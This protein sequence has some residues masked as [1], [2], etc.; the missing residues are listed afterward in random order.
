[1]L[2]III[3]NFFQAQ[4][5]R[6]GSHF[7]A[8]SQNINRDQ[9]QQ[10][11]FA[12]ENNQEVSSARE[13]IE[14]VKG[15][16][17]SQL[18]LSHVM[19]VLPHYPPIFNSSFGLSESKDKDTIYV[20]YD[21]GSQNSDH[22]DPLSGSS[23]GYS[24]HPGLGAYQTQTKIL[25]FPMKNISDEKYIFH[26]GIREVLAPDLSQHENRGPYKFTEDDA[27]E[28]SDSKPKSDTENPK[29]STAV[30]TEHS[31]NY[32]NYGAK[33]SEKFE[34]ISENS[35]S[36][37]N[38]TSEVVRK[39]FASYPWNYRVSKGRFVAPKTSEDEG[40]ESTESLASTSNSQVQSQLDIRKT[41]P[42]RNRSRYNVDGN[43]KKDVRNNSRSRERVIFNNKKSESHSLENQKL[44]SQYS[45]GKKL[46]N[47]NFEEK[48][49]SNQKS[50]IQTNLSKTIFEDNFQESKNVTKVLETEGKSKIEDD[51]EKGKKNE[52]FK[53]EVKDTISTGE[54]NKFYEEESKNLDDV[55]RTVEIESKAME[56][57]SKTVEK[58]SKTVNE[59][60]KSLKE[61][62]SSHSKKT[63]TEAT[64]KAEKQK[65]SSNVYIVTP[66]NRLNSRTKFDIRTKKSPKE[67]VK[68][69]DSV[70]V[71]IRKPTIQGSRVSIR[72]GRFTKKFKNNT[73]LI[74]SNSTLQV[75]N[76]QLKSNS[77]IKMKN[78]KPTP[79]THISRIYAK[80][81]AKDK[82]ISISRTLKP[83]EKMKNEE[84]QESKREIEKFSGTMSEIEKQKEELHLRMAKLFPKFVNNK[85]GNDT[86]V[87]VT[88]KDESEIKLNQTQ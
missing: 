52:T 47:P 4:P 87:F 81:R 24:D 79:E 32:E 19:D 13:G 41:S 80:N 76:L 22:S 5:Y 55:L 34:K 20:T 49:L 58:K 83:E 7:E 38:E 36:R 2:V 25:Y 63:T 39:L 12:S 29:N 85:P 53:E 84:K 59:K 11:L 27:G 35:D 17:T 62:R 48:N 18:E 33:N 75:E 40:K 67:E 46:E 26:D 51:K 3:F 72:E 16:Q 61:E 54:L 71:E 30:S 78:L 8:Y 73:S 57:E 66:S 10:G 21:K 56:E 1:M 44:E 15:N 31:W 23:S 69:T 68:K 60:S 9:D 82:L 88:V 77:S 14:K 86:E 42:Q 6:Y 65:L 45:D 43:L 64:P 37:S 28:E 70:K 50:D 74:K